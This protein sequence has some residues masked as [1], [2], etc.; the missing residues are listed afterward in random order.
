MKVVLIRLRPEEVRLETTIFEGMLSSELGFSS[1]QESRTKLFN[2]FPLPFSFPQIFN[3]DFN[4]A[5]AIRIT[6]LNNGPHS[7]K[8]R[9]PPEKSDHLV[10]IH[11]SVCKFG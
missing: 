4:L 1:V 3:D 5:F 11:K 8:I 7:K 2:W 9:Y 10:I 6:E